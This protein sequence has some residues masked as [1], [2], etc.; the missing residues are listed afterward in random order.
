MLH[1]EFMADAPSQL[2]KILFPQFEIL[3]VGVSEHLSHFLFNSGKASLAVPLCLYRCYSNVVS[4]CMVSVCIWQ[5][6]WEWMHTNPLLQPGKKVNWT[7]THTIILVITAHGWMPDVRN[8]TLLLL[9]FQKSF[10]KQEMFTVRRILVGET[11]F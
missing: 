4:Q 9:D 2:L 8:W 7:N 10:E 3:N 1:L 6:A 11:F 5:K